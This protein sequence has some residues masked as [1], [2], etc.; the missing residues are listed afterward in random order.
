MGD[1][2]SKV[3]T[4]VTVCIGVGMFFGLMIVLI[5]IHWIVN[6]VLFLY[7]FAL[8]AKIREIK[9]EDCPEWARDYFEPEFL[10]SAVVLFPVIIFIGKFQAV[11]GAF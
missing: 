10:A 6:L 8:S 7:S 3:F 1:K 9:K 5:K 4:G 11:T 2:E